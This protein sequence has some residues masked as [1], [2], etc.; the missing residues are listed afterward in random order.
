VSAAQREGLNVTG[1]LGLLDL[2]AE[3]GLVDSVQAIK[4]L[5]RT[6]FHRPEALLEELLRKHTQKGG[7][8]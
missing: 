7:D 6:T 8:A 3:R 4:K 1:T 2:A 5:E